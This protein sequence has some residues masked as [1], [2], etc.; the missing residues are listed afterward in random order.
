MCL[1]GFFVFSGNV[2]A[3]KKPEEQVSE[4]YEYRKVQLEQ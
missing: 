3:E 1:C 2:L 4:S